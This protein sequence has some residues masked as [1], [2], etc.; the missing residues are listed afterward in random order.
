MGQARP[1]ERTQVP[2]IIVP[3]LGK[4]IPL[5]QWFWRE[6]REGGFLNRMLAR[7][8]ADTDR[9]MRRGAE[10]FRSRQPNPKSDMRLKAVIDPRTFFRWFATDRHFWEDPKNVERFV[11]DNP[12]AQ[13]WR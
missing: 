7:E 4:D 2:Q 11:R 8:R 6:L 1:T 9:R 5:T 13:P 3:K 12:A 10:A